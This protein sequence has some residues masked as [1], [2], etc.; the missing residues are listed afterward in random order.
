MGKGAA[1]ARAEEAIRD[2]INNMVLPFN[3][4]QM[5]KGVVPDYC[6]VNAASARSTALKEADV[7]LVLGARLNWI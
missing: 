2:L 5:G 3:P 4:S 7:V 6:S 1:Y